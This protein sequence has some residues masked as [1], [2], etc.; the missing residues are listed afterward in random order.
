MYLSTGGTI[1]PES[2]LAEGGEGAVYLVDG[3]PD[4]VAKV[5]HPSQ[6]TPDRLA[7]LQAMLANPPA[8]P[9]AGQGQRSIAWPLAILYQ[10]S[11]QQQFLGFVMP[12]ASQ[13]ARTILHYY[14][15]ELRRQ[16]APGFNFRYL[17]TAGRNLA[18]A[19]SAIRMAGHRIGDLN[20]SNVLV[21]PEAII[22]LIDTD[23]FQ[24]GVPGGQ[25]FRCL[26]GKP[27]YTSPELAGHS[28]GTTDRTIYTDAFALAVLLFQ[29]LMQGFLPFHG[30]PQQP[31]EPPPVEE[32]IRQGMYVYGGHRDWR[33]PRKAPA[34]DILPRELQTAFYRA[35]VAGTRDP[36]V[37]PTASE[38]VKLLDKLLDHLTECRR[39][40]THVYPSSLW[41]CPWCRL[42]SEKQIDYFPPVPGLQIRLSPPGVTRPVEERREYLVSHISTAL[43]DGFLT[44][45]EEKHL[46]GLAQV[47]GLESDLRRLLDRELKRSGAMRGSPQAPQHEPASLRFQVG[48]IKFEAVRPCTGTQTQTVTYVN[49]GRGALRGKVRLEP[50]GPFSVSPQ[51]LDRNEGQIVISLDSDHV[52]W[53]RVYAA[54]LVVEYNGK[55]PGSEAQLRLTAQTVPH[56]I[57]NEWLQSHARRGY[58]Y[59]AALGLILAGWAWH[60][61]QEP[62]RLMLHGLFALSG[63]NSGSAS[64]QSGLLGLISHPDFWWQHAI[65]IAASITLVRIATRF[66]PTIATA[67]RLSRVVGCL[68]FLTLPSILGIV[69]SLSG[70]GEPA[71]VSTIV[72]AG[73]VTLTAGSPLVA[74]MVASHLLLPQLRRWLVRGGR[75]RRALSVASLWAP[76]SAVLAA[77][78]VVLGLGL[79]PMPSTLRV[80]WPE[81]SRVPDPSVHA[82]GNLLQQVVAVKEFEVIWPGGTKVRTARACA[83]LPNTP[84][85]LVQG[86]RVR[87][88]DPQQH[89]PGDGP[90]ECAPTGWSQIEQGWVPSNTLAPLS[91]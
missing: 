2:R 87:L 36:H 61:R 91:N 84:V 56:S 47:L 37:R 52:D 43:T 35:F 17:A 51:H 54:R 74:Q 88:V 73:A 60:T 41:G 85:L 32:R 5:Y 1:I 34:V 66:W 16:Y 83:A 14:Q 13:D 70:W 22:T 21:T 19:T 48:E 12:R 23:S 4:W 27:D 89:Q 9:M 6:R 79:A 11:G 15:P 8:D 50:P 25:V 57:I 69:L 90:E 33:P 86:T 46:T 29:M 10:D 18:A 53:E 24:V 30:R 20:E 44:P 82:A 38:W 40:P 64:E 7:K 63:V 49:S 3:H 77:F 26:V 75:F 59:Q 67:L 72:A 80:G 76:G 62:V 68:V 78:S 58:R 28:F 45:D 42:A 31:G 65:S 81:L 71:H 39:N 55:L